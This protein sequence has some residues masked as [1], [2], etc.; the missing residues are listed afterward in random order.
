LPGRN[1]RII[2]LVSLALATAGT[3]GCAQSPASHASG[4]ASGPASSA[5]A[6]SST[7]AHLPTADE[8]ACA[9]V[10]GVI[11][12]IA[13]DTSGWSP[14]QKPFDQAMSVRIARSSRDLAAQGPQAHS[15][16][17]RAAVSANA[18]AFETLAEAMGQKKLGRVRSAIAETRPTYKVLKATCS[19]G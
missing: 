19:L 1:Q 17:I 15:V 6:P 14:Q 18:R 11:G 3:A 8:R 16:K 2:A 9:G 5:A 12:H 10:Q 13:S 7:P 4:P